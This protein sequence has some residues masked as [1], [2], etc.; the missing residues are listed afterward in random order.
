MLPNQ[1]GFAPIVEEHFLK[2]TRLSEALEEVMSVYLKAE[3]REN[4]RQFLNEFVSTVLWTVA[5]RF[6]VKQGLSC[7]SPEIIVGGDDYSLFCVFGQVAEGPLRLDWVR[8]SE[9]AA[10]AEFFYFVSRVAAFVST[11]LT[12]FHSAEAPWF[13]FLQPF[14]SICYLV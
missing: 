13:P 7:S 9:K 11:S 6:L 5:P 1:L 2:R 10:N 12:S 4:C 3:F 14:S 8:C